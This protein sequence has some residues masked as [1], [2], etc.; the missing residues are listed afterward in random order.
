MNVTRCRGQVNS[1]HVLPRLAP[2]PS[3]TAVSVAAKEVVQV[4]IVLAV[5]ATSNVVSSHCARKKCPR[6]HRRYCRRRRNSRHRRTCAR[7]RN[8]CRKVYVRA[9]TIL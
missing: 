6:R 9:S 2:L 1:P 3:S 7:R 5:T 8:C 4:L